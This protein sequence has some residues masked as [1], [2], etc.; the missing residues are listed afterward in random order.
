MKKELIAKIKQRKA[1]IAV[2]GL[3]RVGLPIAAIFANV[4]YKVTGVDLKKE[5]VDA[6][7]SVKVYIKE[8]GLEIVIKKVLASGKFKAT[9]NAAKAVREADIVIICVQTPIT[10]RR[11]PNLTYLQRACKDVAEGLPKGKL[12]IVESTVPPQ[13]MRNLVTKVIEKTS[14]LKSGKDFWLVY[15]PERITSG[16]VL[17]ELTESPRIIGA[18]NAESAEVAVELLRT[19]T[20]GKIL[21]TDLETAEVAKLAENAFRDTNIA[22]ANELALICEHLGVDVM[23][24]IKAANTHPRVN[25]HRPGCGVGGPCLTKDP[26]LLLHPAKKEGFNS[27]LIRASRKINDYMPEHIVALLVTILEETGKD[28]SDCKVAVLGLAYK[29]DTQDVTNSP[30]EIIVSKL[31]RL[32]AE[33]IVYDP[34]CEESFRAK[35]A[36]DIM[37]ALKEA[38]AML[39]VTDHKV[40]K[41]VNLEKIKG[42]MKDNPVVVDGRRVFDAETV[43]KHGFQYYGIGFIA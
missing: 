14:S 33:V 40:F 29:G 4:G 8:P 16:R 19:V 17:Q 22:F 18:Y 39:V 11:K 21:I 6:I 23:R 13:T 35:K 30:A 31:L 7:S 36:M 9:T 41:E 38:D 3:G 43:K 27:G 26:Y 12:I 42:L 1:K 24:V 5:I 28:V 34:Y 32:G 37:D 20:K 15:S 2:V 25:I 10:G